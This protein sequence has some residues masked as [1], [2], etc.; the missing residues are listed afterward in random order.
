MLVTKNL[1]CIMKGIRNTKDGLWDV[2]LQNHPNPKTQ[3]HHDN[4]K[5]PRKHS[6]YQKQNPSKQICIVTKKANKITK[7]QTVR[8]HDITME[9]LDK[10]LEDQKIK[11]NKREKVNIIIHKKQAKSKLAQFLHATCF[12][13]VTSTF[14]KAI[15]NNN[16]TTWP[17]LTEQLILRHLPTSIATLKGHMKQEFQGLQSTKQNNMPHTVIAAAISEDS[18]ACEKPSNTNEIICMVLETG[19]Q[20]KGH[21]DLTGR[22]PYKSA[23]GNQY[24]LVIF[25]VN[26]N[27]ILAEPIKNREAETITKGWEKINNRIVRAGENHLYTL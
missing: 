7:I 14:V 18:Q 2:P 17:G 9:A 13:P 27:A 25:H 6:I 21:M 10:I 16:F 12:S 22:F 26:A 24:I 1:E 23:Q 19:E 20:N 15:K 5:M 8:E 4:F 3:I 11:D